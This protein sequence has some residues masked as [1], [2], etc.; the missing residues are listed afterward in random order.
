MNGYYGI[1]GITALQFIALVYTA[2]GPFDG[3][4]L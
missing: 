4:A 2:G 1:T 3:V